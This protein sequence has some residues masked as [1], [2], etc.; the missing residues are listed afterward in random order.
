MLKTENIH[1]CF[2]KTKGTQLETESETE[3]EP[4]GCF[5]PT[6]PWCVLNSR[7]KLKPA[8]VIHGHQLRRK[9]L[10][11]KRSDLYG[12]HLFWGGAGGLTCFYRSNLFGYHLLLE[13]RLVW[14]SPF[15]KGHASLGFRFF[16]W[17]SPIFKGQTC[18]GFT[19]LLKVRFVWPL[20]CVTNEVGT[21]AENYGMV[22]F[23][24]KWNTIISLK[25]KTCKPVRLWILCLN[26]CTV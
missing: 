21:M 9:E 26:H 4:R 25:S 15:I 14:V 19:S 11:T 16:L 17:V 3:T 24:R 23:K 18:L 13:V 22:I 5:R 6:F 7:S 12:F 20:M 2:S 10:E 1:I 8:N